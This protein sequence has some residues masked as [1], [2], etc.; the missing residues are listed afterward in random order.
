MGFECKGSLTANQTNIDGLRKRASVKSQEN[1]LSID[2]LSL[3]LRV[4]VLHLLHL[5]QQVFKRSCS[6]SFEFY[7]GNNPMRSIEGA[8]H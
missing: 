8:V 2:F 3:R 1:R 7:F 6:V 4:I 5:R